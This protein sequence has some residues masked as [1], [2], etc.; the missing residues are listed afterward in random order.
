VSVFGANYLNNALLSCSFGTVAGQ[1][2]TWISAGEL[3]CSA[4]AGGVSGTVALRVSS[5][6]Q[7]YSSTSVDY[8]Y[9]GASA[10]VCMESGG[11][12]VHASCAVSHVGV[13]NARHHLYDTVLSCVFPHVNANRASSG[14]VGGTMVTAVGTNF[15]ASTS[16][17]C[18]FDA[19]TSSII[20]ISA[21][22]VKCVSPTHDTGAASFAVSLNGLNFVTGLTFTYQGLCCCFVLTF[23]V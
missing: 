4:P 2:A 15:A 3:R 1:S 13:A 19:F 7:Q 10:F 21:T 8:L 22:A 5:N 16:A 23:L 12:T 14:T 20:F 11:L 17:V 6:N 9:H 18:R